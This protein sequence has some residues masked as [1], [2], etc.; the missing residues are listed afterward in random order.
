MKKNRKLFRFFLSVVLVCVL[1][2]TTVMTVF[3]AGS[4]SKTKTVSEQSAI[5]YAMTESGSE[6]APV[7]EIVESIRDE[8]DDEAAANFED[9]MDNP[10]MKAF[11]LALQQKLEAEFPGM[12]EEDRNEKLESMSDEDTFALMEKIFNDPEIIRLS[13]AVSEDEELAEQMDGLLEILLGGESIVGDDAKPEKLLS[14]NQGDS[15]RWTL[16]INGTLTIRGSG[17]IVPSYEELAGMNLPFYEWDD[18]IDNITGIVIK[19]G[20]TAVP[21]DAFSYSSALK[22]VW[23]PASV[24]SIDS[25]A[26]VYCENLREVYFQGDAPEIAED[27]FEECSKELTLYY[28][29]GTKGWDK[30]MDY[31]LA[32]WSVASAAES[33]EERGT[34]QTEIKEQSVSSDQETAP[35]QETG[36]VITD[37]NSPYTGDSI[38][39]S[40]ILLMAAA[41]ICGGVIIIRMYKKDRS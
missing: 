16:D 6:E 39:W 36:K 21:E 10:N 37:S 38:M 9:M 25:E 1:Y 12:S 34:A 33:S 29:E 4:Q 23:I 19:D 15:I 7:E 3:A 41:V 14:G 32:V 11:I 28:R 22:T 31:N 24:K 18:Y 27:A 30:V 20:V 26:F 13:E 40:F 8:Y 17:S 5:A 35:P 2:F